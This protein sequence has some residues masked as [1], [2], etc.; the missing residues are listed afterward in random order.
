LRLQVLRL[1]L[2]QLLGEAM[3]GGIADMM[4]P[5]DLLRSFIPLGAAWVLSQLPLSEPSKVLLVRGAFLAQS[6]AC[7]ALTMAIRMSIAR[8]AKEE[9][10][11]ELVTVEAT[12]VA[13][14]EMKKVKE[15]LTVFQYDSKT[16]REST[17][18]HIL[19]SVIVVVMHLQ[20]EYTIPLWCFS[21]MRGLQHWEAPLCKVH[22]R[23]L[24][25]KEDETLKRP[26]GSGSKF[27]LYE[28]IY[29]AQSDMKA[30]QGTAASGR[31]AKKASKREAAAAVLEKRKDSAKKK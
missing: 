12:E 4:N 8:R 19:G 26:F 28:M 16:L 2:L 7:M 30:S 22:V 21:V 20:Y 23:G 10:D 27:S 11:S 3:S 25:F 14:G 31:G 24:S 15:Q 29:R 9:S 1:Q 18:Q 13:D 17:H 5:K 6:I